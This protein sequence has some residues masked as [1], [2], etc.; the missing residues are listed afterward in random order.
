MATGRRAFDGD[1]QAALTASILARHPPPAS[2]VQPSLPPNFDHLVERCL[3][4]DPDER[5]QSARD[6]LFELR[7][8]AE[9]SPAVTRSPRR[10]R[11]AMALGAAALTTLGAL[12]GMLINR[13]SGT[14][15]DRLSR[16]QMALP[17]GVRLPL[18]EARTSIAVSPDGRFVAMAPMTQGT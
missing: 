7:W 17:P 5:W 10:S 18:R 1:S 8:I 15:G 6:V 2:S 14:A 13:D 9:L 4:K 16:L 11:T 12:G 3:A